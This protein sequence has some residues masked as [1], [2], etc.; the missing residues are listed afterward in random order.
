MENT[1]MYQKQIT[2][3]QGICFDLYYSIVTRTVLN[4]CDNEEV[5][6]GVEISKYKDGILL[7]QE[8]VHCISVCKNEIEQWIASL[9]ET[10]TTPIALLSL[11]DDFISSVGI[12]V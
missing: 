3:E 1:A 10:Q 8:V 7:E 12:A 9:A 6:Y 4:E 2:D 11:A 5:A